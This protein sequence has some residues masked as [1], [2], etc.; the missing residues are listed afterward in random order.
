MA[1]LPMYDPS[2]RLEA[3]HRVNSPGGYEWWFFEACGS[4]LRIAISVM[5][6]D[7]MRP[8]Y[9]RRYVEYRRHPTRAAPPVPSEFPAVQYAI[10]EREKLL[11]ASEIVYPPNSLQG[12]TETTEI[13][14]GPCQ[15]KREGNGVFLQIVEPPGFRAELHLDSTL[16]HPATEVSLDRCAAQCAGRLIEFHGLGYH[17]HLFGTSPPFEGIQSWIRG[18]VLFADCAYLVD[19]GFAKDGTS[20]RQ[21]LVRADQNGVGRVP[22]SSFVIEGLR[23]NSSQLSYASKLAFDDILEL[24]NPR[25]LRATASQVHLCFDARQGDRRATAYCE[26]LHSPV[27]F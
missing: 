21:I 13:G 18:R 4:D 27:E 2:A 24:T 8:S 3:W 14:I 15:L 6:G 17:D 1:T 16:D 7:F 10:Y 11:R 25:I 26:I 22:I 19:L 5:D 9:A 23:G 20:C 12:S